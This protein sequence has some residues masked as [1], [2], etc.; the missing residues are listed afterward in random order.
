MARTF[1][2][3][4]VK[5]TN[6]QTGEKG[7]VKP[8]GADE[9]S[10]LDGSS[11]F[12]CFA[13]KSKVIVDLTPLFS[14]GSAL[15]PGDP[16]N[17]LVKVDWYEIVF[18]GKPYRGDA[19]QESPIEVNNHEANYGL[20]PRLVFGPE[21]PGNHTLGFRASVNGQVGEEPHTLKLNG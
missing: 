7:H 21:L 1:S 11:A 9:K 2:G 10:Y 16:E 19:I 8:I 20:T 15:Q 3:L 18:D 14:D 6:P 12:N 13:Q 4:R 17:E 5:F